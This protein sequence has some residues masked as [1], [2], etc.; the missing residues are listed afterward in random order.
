MIKNTFEV[1][2][3]IKTHIIENALF[4]TNIIC[5]LL[6]VPLNLENVTKNALIPFMIRSGSKKYKTQLEINKHLEE[7]Y[8]A[9]FDCG[10][11]KMGDNQ[12]LKFYIEGINDSFLP[13]KDN[14]LK[15][16]SNMLF[17]LVFNTNIEDGKFGDEILKIEKENLRQ[18]IEGRIDDKD[19]YAFETCIS[20]MYGENGFGLF[21]YGRLEDIEKINS[22]DLADHYNKLIQ[23][24]KIDIFVSGNLEN[25]NFESILEENEQIKSL[26]PRSENYILNNEYTEIKQNVDNIQEIQEKMDITQGK[27][28]IGLDILSKQEN[29]Q[30]VALVYNSILG[31]GANS[32]LFQNVREKESLAYTARSMYIRQKGNIFIRCGIEIE[33]YDRALK[34]IKEQVSS[35]ESGNFSD[36]DI[37]NAKRYL[38]AG[39][40]AIPEDQDSELIFYIGAEISKTEESLEFYID[41]IQSVTKEEI[42]EFAR[43]IQYNTIYFLKGEN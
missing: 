13:N 30:P 6:T 29:L 27:L 22:K 34:L 33:N 37:E 16:M 35:I 19:F 39:I 14:L 17:E 21:K 24:A 7:M 1:K 9:S 15:E 32:M 41:K 31:N 18:V 40:R 38:I 26:V 12:I 23:S 25:E 28:V 11:D 3:G 5:V 8:G 43:Q 2:Q 42:L 20:K 4:K 36:E 10:I